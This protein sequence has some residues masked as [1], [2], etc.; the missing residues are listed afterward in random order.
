MA[1]QEA[2]RQGNLFQYL[3][4]AGLIAMFSVANAR[5]TEEAARHTTDAV[6]GNIAQAN[7]EFMSQIGEQF[8]SRAMNVQPTLT[9]DSGTSVN[10]MINRNISLPPLNPF[11]VAQRHILE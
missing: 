5:M 2:V 9:V 1:G 4:A 7:T 3:Q 8:V 10:V 6:A 11:A